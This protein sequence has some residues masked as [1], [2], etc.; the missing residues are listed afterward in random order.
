MSLK[1]SSSPSLTPMILVINRKGNCRIIQYPDQVKAVIGDSYPLSAIHL[2]TE[3]NIETIQTQAITVLREQTPK[4]FSTSLLLQGQSS[5]YFGYFFPLSLASVLLIAQPVERFRGQSKEEAIELFPLSTLLYDAETLQI[6]AVNQSAIAQYGYSETEFLQMQL[7]QL[8]PSSQT[9]D[10]L[11][12]VSDLVTGE[13]QNCGKDRKLIY[14]ALTAYPIQTP[15][16]K[17]ILLLAQ[18]I[19]EYCHTRIALHHYTKIAVPEKQDSET[20][21][22]PNFPPCG[23]L[24]FNREW[25]YTLAVGNALSQITQ[26]TMSEGEESIEGKQI[27]QV[28]S[29]YIRERLAPLQEQILLGYSQSYSFQYHQ[30]TYYLQ[31]YPLRNQKEQIIGGFLMIKNLTLSKHVEALLDKHTFYDLT[32]HLPNQTWFLEELSRQI[33]TLP[34]E[35]VAVFLLRLE[36]YGIMKQGLGQ[37]LANQLMVAVA[38]RLKQTLELDSDFARVGDADLAMF[39]PQL[40]Q[41]QEVERI[42]QLIHFQLS[43]AIE[44]E[45]Q[46]LFCPVS[47]GVAIYQAGLDNQEF[48]QDPS[49]ILH[50]ADTAMNKAQ[51]KPMSPCVIFHP[52]LRYSAANR[53]QLETQLRQALRLKELD[54]FYQPTVTLA[55]GKLTGFEALVRWQH[56]QQGLVSPSRFIPLAEELGLIGLIDWWVL[57]E[58]CE[59]LAIWQETILE[60]DSLLMMNVNLSEN[61]INQVGILERLEQIIQRTGINP[62][63]LKLEVTEGIILE[64]KTATTSILRRLKAMG[65]ALSIDDFGTG[66]SSLQRLHQLPINTLKI[67]RSFTKRMLKSPAILQITKTIINLAHDLNMEVIAEGIEEREQWKALKSLNC[68]YGQ[69]F[70]FGKPLSAVE[71]RDLIL[72]HRSDL[73]LL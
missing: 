68:E 59:N 25:D 40:T 24:G 27:C 48:L 5:P 6:Q 55:E 54:V 49:A 22:I 23:I 37:K 8:Y 19:T 4:P 18:D 31:G 70:L 21:S 35:G 29:P 17:T 58:A 12:N 56:P 63:S 26:I 11:Q 20:K 53:V 71:T 61:M 1:E 45:E 64:G 16:T 10:R 7:P 50:A 32:T 28:F 65:V 73:I 69:G 38:K 47:I 62:A 72:A 2:L 44:I 9:P 15:E 33:K 67:D 39:F 13:W 43:L 51:G 42:A 41:Q 14:V 3:E 57:V 36:R 60:Q 46:E 52:Q 34:E 30:Y 66:Y